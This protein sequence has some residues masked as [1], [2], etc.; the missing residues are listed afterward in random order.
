MLQ[1][2]C[3][4]I[5][6]YVDS[7]LEQ[8]PLLGYGLFQCCI[9]KRESHSDVLLTF[10]T[11][12]FGTVLCHICSTVYC[13]NTLDSSAYLS[14]LSNSG[15]DCFWMYRKDKCQRGTNRNTHAHKYKLAS[16]HTVVCSFLSLLLFSAC[17]HH[18]LLAA[19]FFL[20]IKESCLPFYVSSTQ[21]Y[22]FTQTGTLERI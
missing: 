17:H 20:L 15:A 18:I 21:K 9:L 7:V 11:F 8:Q 3:C 14:E 12:C 4:W 13:S 1:C 22:C 16:T 5:M 2:L 6:D 10:S 19:V